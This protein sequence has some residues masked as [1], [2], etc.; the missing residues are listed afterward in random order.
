MSLVKKLTRFFTL[1]IG[2]LVAIAA[3]LIF[4][5]E[6][7]IVLTCREPTPTCLIRY[8][9]AGHLWSSMGAMGAAE[10]WYKRGAD[11]SDPIAMF[12]LG[13]LHE[14]QAWS[15]VVAAGF[16]WQR[17]LGH[18]EKLLP[19]IAS[20]KSMPPSQAKIFI[21]RMVDKMKFE[22]L[23]WHAPSEERVKAELASA[24]LWYRRSADEGFAPAMNNLGQLY[25]EGRGIERDPMEAHRWSL[26]AAKAGNP[27]GA[28]NVVILASGAGERNPKEMKEWSTYFPENANLD[29]LKEPT[30]ERTTLFGGSLPEEKG[31][32]IRQAA[33][34]KSPM[35]FSLESMRP[36]PS[37]PK[38]QKVPGMA[39]SDSR[40]R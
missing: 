32:Q 34:A 31:Q 10:E 24:Y 7:S 30:L 27:V 18:V 13:W 11:A 37:M 14:Q 1:G 26:A 20:V 22:V 35:W 33:L 25:A 19:R 36:E 28:M 12:H 16:E 6:L 15:N 3:V 5:W 9:A 17:Q 2:G 23:Y 38:F 21:N 40:P 29:D 39:E 4:L 8:R